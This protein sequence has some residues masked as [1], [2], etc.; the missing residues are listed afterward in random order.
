MARYIDAERL[1]A[2]IKSYPDISFWAKQQEIEIVDNTP[3]IDAVEVVRCKDC[4]HW[5]TH[6]CHIDYEYFSETNEND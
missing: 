6:G 5:K 1:K 4:K 3:T 2:E